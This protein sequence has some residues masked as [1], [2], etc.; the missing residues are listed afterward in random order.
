M[1]KM[2]KKRLLISFLILLFCSI[3]IIAQIDTL[4]AVFEFDAPTEN[5]WGITYDGTN[6]WIGD[7]ENGTIYK[8][9]IDGVVLDSMTINGAMIKGIEIVNDTLWALNSNLVGDSVFSLYQMDMASGT[10]HDSIIIYTPY[11]NNFSGM[12]WGLCYNQ[13]YFYISFDGGYGPCLL[14]INPVS[15][16]QQSLCCTHLSGLASINDSVWAI[17]NSYY[18]KTTDGQQEFPKYR[19]NIYASDL[20][21]DG[22]SFWVV[23]MNSNTIHQLEPVVLSNDDKMHISKGFLIAPNPTEGEIRLEFGLTYVEKIELS[24]IRGQIVKT[25]ILN[26]EI[27]NY[28]FDVCDVESGVYLIRIFSTENQF[29]RKIIIR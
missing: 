25:A 8:T 19:T 9:N 7:V 5:A 16:T 27:S 24:D 13:P 14:K 11:S 20:T 18:I 21:F 4:N 28:Q 26:K 22:N 23:N 2:M 15:H 6:L 3:K 10:I 29:T 1:Q 12:M 17:R